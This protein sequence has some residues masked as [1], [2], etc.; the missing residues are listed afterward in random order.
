MKGQIS[1]AMNLVFLFVLVISILV[2]FSYFSVIVH[3]R[4]A[5]KDTLKNAVLITLYK[6]LFTFVQI[7]ALLAVAILTWKFKGIIL[8]FSASFFAYVYY[9]F[10]DRKYATLVETDV[11]GKE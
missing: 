3:L 1:T 8:F 9:M 6:P 10:F 7:A 5:M 4:L 11:V 2:M